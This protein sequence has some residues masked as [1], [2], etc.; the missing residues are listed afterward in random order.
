MP[1][2]LARGMITESEWLGLFLPCTFLL[3]TRI[4]SL[5]SLYSAPKSFGQ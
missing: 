2:D 5:K 4:L 1:H 3:E